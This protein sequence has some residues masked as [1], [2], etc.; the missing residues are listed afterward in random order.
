MVNNGYESRHQMQ[1]SMAFTYML[2][3]GAYE[4]QTLRKRAGQAWTTFHSFRPALRTRGPLSAHQRLRI[5][6]IVLRDCLCRHHRTCVQTA[7]IDLGTHA[8]SQGL[9]HPRARCFQ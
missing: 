8:A 1:V 4:Q 5:A 3:Y 6:Y 9:A 2:P 7:R